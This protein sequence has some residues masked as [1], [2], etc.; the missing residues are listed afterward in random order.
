MQKTRD[1][2]NITGFFYNKAEYS[3]RKFLNI[4]RKNSEAEIPDLMVIMMNPGSSRQLKGYED[5]LEKVVPTIPDNTQDQIMRV[6]NNLSLNFA[7]VLNLSDMRETKCTVLYQKIE[8]IKNT[9]IVH[10]IFD[11][12]RK[13]DFK[14]LFVKG[15]PV[16]CAWGV[17]EKLSD[18]AQMALK[19]IKNAK[20]AGIQK[21]GMPYAYY[22]PLPQNFNKQKEWVV[23]ITKQ[24]KTL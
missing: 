5:V 1:Y 23:E 7:R 24:L 2:F 4:K 21:E 8:K 22:H 20:I 12:R 14:S 15:V 10:S 13:K 16:I 18:L 17:N 3:F 6:M 11:E 19:S 9:D